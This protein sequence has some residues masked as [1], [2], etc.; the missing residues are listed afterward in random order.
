ML[1]LFGIIGF[2]AHAVEDVVLQKFYAEIKQATEEYDKTVADLRSKTKDVKTD[3]ASNID[4]SKNGLNQFGFNFDGFCETWGIEDKGFPLENGKCAKLEK[5]GTWWVSFSWWSDVNMV[6]GKAKCDK[7]IDTRYVTDNEKKAGC[8]CKITAIDDKII[9]NSDWF[10]WGN[11]NTK[12][13][14][15][16]MCATSCA[17]SLSKIES[18]RK[19]AL[20]SILDNKK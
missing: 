10:Y 5:K 4:L 17:Y 20:G 13:N 1:S 16:H 15:N 11:K 19:E 3:G 7:P 2:N 6:Y 14:C 18:T 12:E 8:F 9:K